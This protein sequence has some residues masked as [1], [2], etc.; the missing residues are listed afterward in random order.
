MKKRTILALLLSIVLGLLCIGC[1]QEE[2]LFRI[3]DQNT[4]L[5]GYANQRGKIVI[6]CQYD[7]YDTI[8]DDTQYMVCLLYTSRCV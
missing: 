1:G 6:E 2:Q 7:G 5:I 4:G 3:E 8:R